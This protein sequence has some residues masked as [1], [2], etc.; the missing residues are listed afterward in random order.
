[1]TGAAV[2]S[3]DRL[4]GIQVKGADAM[5]A[6]GIFFRRGIALPL[7]GQHMN[8]NRGF[9]VAD[10]FKGLDQ[11]FQPMPPDRAHVIEMEGRKEHPRGEKTGQRILAFLGPLEQRFPNP[12][13]GF[14]KGFH[15][16]FELDEPLPG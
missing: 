6:G 14:E 16:P 10:I 12:R 5:K 15:F 9:Q 11:G 4:P 7:G 3:F 2:F 1:M 13:Q 8:Q